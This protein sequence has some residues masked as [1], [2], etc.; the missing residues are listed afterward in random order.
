MYRQSDQ[1]QTGTVSEGTDLIISSFRTVA[2]GGRTHATGADP[3][4]LSGRVSIQH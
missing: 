3:T 1:K 4:F 2:C